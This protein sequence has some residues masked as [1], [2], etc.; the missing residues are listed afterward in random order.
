MTAEPSTLETP[1]YANR[2]PRPLAGG[3]SSGAG[4]Q[5]PAARRA[6]VRTVDLIL[7]CLRA[8]EQ[9]AA[10]RASLHAWIARRAALAPAAG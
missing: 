2:P 5:G 6:E 3:A 7:L 8:Y 4:T 1:R 9:R 10:R